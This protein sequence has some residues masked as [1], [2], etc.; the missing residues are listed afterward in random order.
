MLYI[1]IFFLYI[2]ITVMQGAEP[3]RPSEGDALP[4]V[5]RGDLSPGRACDISRA[6]KGL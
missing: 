6:G 5:T 4:Q 3:V 2:Y 1:H